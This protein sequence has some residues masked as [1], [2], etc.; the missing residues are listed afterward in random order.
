MAQSYARRS[1]RLT[2]RL[3]LTG[4]TLRM[5]IIA[6]GLSLVLLVPANPRADRLLGFLLLLLGPV[7]IAST[8]WLSVRA[9]AA[10]IRVRNPLRRYRVP[11]DKVELISSVGGW[12]YYD[13]SHVEI[14]RGGTW[15]LPDGYPFALAVTSGLGHAERAK[16]V[17]DLVAEARAHGFDI[18]TA[19][20]QQ[21]E[22]WSTLVPEPAAAPRKSEQAFR[23][24]AYTAAPELVQCVICGRL[25][26]PAEMEPFGE[27]SEEPAWYCR[28]G[29]ACSRL[30]TA[31]QGMYD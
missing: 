28:D 15:A 8:L 26:R 14:M 25:R 3:L 5:M 9:D 21:W 20:G 18:K 4:W 6:A 23:Q 31:A 22:V 12:G 1:W 16:I 24:R 19:S 30:E 27:E 11:W 17:E 2:L 10:G 7:A 13:P 29:D